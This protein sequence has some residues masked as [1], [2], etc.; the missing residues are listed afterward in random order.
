MKLKSY[1][2]TQDELLRGYGLELTGEDEAE[3][4]LC[5]YEPGESVV[6]EGESLAYFWLMVSGRAKLCRSTAAGESL[7]LCY[8]V[9][10]G[11]I[12]EVELLTGRS[13]ACATVMAVTPLVCLRLSLRFCQKALEGNLVFL[14]C[15]GARLAE[16]LYV[17]TGSLV[18]AALYT[19][20]QRLCAY[21]LEHEQGGWYR[22]T[23]TSTAPALGISYRH[24]SRLVRG[25]CGKGLLRKD[26]SGY[27]IVNKRALR[28]LAGEAWG[29]NML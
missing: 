16:K 20:E 17:N 13:A 29:Q 23:L 15:L 26:R 24:L 4:R 19:G 7:L 8:Y 11:I 25:L 12:G 21:L 18:S 14:R 6:E 1:D 9:E 28:R 3:C 27:K 5:F 10:T 2:H 22:A